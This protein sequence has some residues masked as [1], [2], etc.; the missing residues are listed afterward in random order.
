MLHGS[1]IHT[2]ASDQRSMDSLANLDTEA[3]HP[4]PYR[5]T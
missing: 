4:L 2:Q 1:M 3:I 5:Y